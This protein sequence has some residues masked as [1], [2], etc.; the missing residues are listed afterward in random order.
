GKPR[1][2]C[3]FHSATK[4]TRPDSRNFQVARSISG[5]PPASRTGHFF[6]LD[7][8]GGMR[9]IRRV[10]GLTIAPRGASSGVAT[11]PVWSFVLSILNVTFSLQFMLFSRSGREKKGLAFNCFGCRIVFNSQAR[12]QI[13]L[14]SQKRKINCRRTFPE[15]T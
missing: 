14:E 10:S 13:F 9:C 12:N 5:G 15:G 11:S 7:C 3:Q 4:P 1:N 2:S 6:V 8:P